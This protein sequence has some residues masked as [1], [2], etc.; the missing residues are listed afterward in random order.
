[1]ICLKCN[2]ANCLECSTLTQCTKCNTGL[3]TLQ[4]SC[5][6]I[7]P[8]G[9]A[10]SSSAGIL[11]CIPCKTGCK[12]CPVSVNTCTLCDTN[13]QIDASDNC[14][15]VPNNCLSS[16]YLNSLGSCSSCDQTC[17]TCFGGLRINCLT[18]RTPEYQ[19]QTDN[20]CKEMCTS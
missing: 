2:I 12:S 7:C 16:Q 17:L 15:P 5:Y 9:Y 19:F 8:Q 18:C 4:G 10:P 20:S 14:I 1:M 11:S 3:Y 6:T 13:L